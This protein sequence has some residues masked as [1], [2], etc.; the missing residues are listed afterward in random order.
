[1]R[2]ASS[3]ARSG[4]CASAPFSS[5]EIFEPSYG[6][7]PPAVLGGG[8]KLVFVS[9]LMLGSSGF[10]LRAG[11]QLA[12]VANSDHE[13]AQ[14]VVIGSTFAAPEATES[15]AAEWGARLRGIRISPIH[16]FQMF[17]REFRKN[18]L[19]ISGTFDPV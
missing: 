17:M 3:S 16:E 14:V 12:D 10:D 7:V 6:P 18:K 15:A 11:R 9:D 8:G 13:I 4:A 2:P 5:R 19:V 1:L